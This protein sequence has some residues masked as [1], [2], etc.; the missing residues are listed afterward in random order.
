[1]EGEKQVSDDALHTFQ[2]PADPYAKLAPL[3]ERLGVKPV[4][5]GAPASVMFM[6]Q[7]KGYDI[8]DVI[9]ALLDRLDAAENKNPRRSGG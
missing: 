4:D 2:V 7:G 6:S 9:N 5:E 1:M 8:F 3:A